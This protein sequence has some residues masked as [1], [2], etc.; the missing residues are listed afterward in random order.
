MKIVV[1]LFAMC[2]DVVGEESVRLDLPGGSKA[3]DVWDVLVRQFPALVP[4][5]SISRVA[6]NMKY[7]DESEAVKDGDE[8]CVIPP[9][10]G[11]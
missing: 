6:I 8:V 9:V 10:S 7:A 11:G 5:R 4:Y 1:K 3:S 2:R